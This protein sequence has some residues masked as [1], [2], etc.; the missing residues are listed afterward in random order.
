M[1]GQMSFDTP[2]GTRGRRPVGAGMRWLNKLAIRRIR[3]KGGT[4]MGI[5]TLLLTTIGRKSGL[6]RTSPVGWFPG[7]DGD[8]LIVA[9]AGG[10][11]KNPQWYHNLAAHPDKVRIEVEDRMV[12]VVAEQ[13][14]DAE[15]AAA[16]QQITA[17]VPRFVQYQRKTDRELPI[18]RLVARPD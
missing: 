17:A 18:I 11:V 2:D 4:F 6:E 10:G 16:W 8:W 7:T 5:N 1:E 15:R 9:S 14:H 13:L 3:R 12:A